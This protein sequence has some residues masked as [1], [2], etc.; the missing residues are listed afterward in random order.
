MTTGRIGNIFDHTTATYKFFWFISILQIY[1]KDRGN[2]ISV[3]DIV[4]RMVANAWYPIHYFRLSFGSL[5]SLFSI[6][7][8]LQQLA[9]IPI[10]ASVD[11]VAMQLAEKSREDSNIKNALQKLTLNVPFRFLTPWIRYQSDEQILISSQALENECLYSLYK[12]ENDFYIVINPRWKAY[13]KSHYRIL[14]DF[15]YWNLTEFLQKRN[16][17]VPAISSKII[18]P[19]IRCSLNKQHKF[20]DIVLSL[21]GNFKCIYTGKPLHIGDYDLDHFIPWSFVS[22]D[23][24]WNLIPSDGS[25]NSSK[26][27][28]LPD[29]DIY[30]PRMANEQRK[31]LRLYIQSNHK[32]RVLDDYLSL[33]YSANDLMAMSEEAFLDVYEKTFRPMNQVALNMGFERWTPQDL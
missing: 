14:M 22:H 30:L 17:N 9:E 24:L 18:K 27:N 32:S 11:G 20:W 2:R 26:S 7:K 29:I 12:E 10:E 13:L 15:A 25:I 6:V 3:W 19:E 8:E 33:G 5:D 16:P 1:V 28:R 23:L 21:D 31:A 4:A